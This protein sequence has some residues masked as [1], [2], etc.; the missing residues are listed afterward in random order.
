MRRF[1][2]AP[3]ENCLPQLASQVEQASLGIIRDAIEDAFRR[4]DLSPLLRTH[5]LPE[6]AK[7]GNAVDA[8]AFGIEAYDGAAREDISKEFAANQF[9]FRAGP[10]KLDRTIS[11]VSA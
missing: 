7:V 5:R 6:P 11:G 1:G 4:V 8:S 9:E 2:E 3:R 10:G